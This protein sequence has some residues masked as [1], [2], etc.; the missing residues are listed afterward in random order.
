MKKPF[1]LI[2]IFLLL[3]SILAILLLISILILGMEFW[4]VRKQIEGNEL[5]N[6]DPK[7]LAYLLLI[8]FTLIITLLFDFKILKLKTISVYKDWVKLSLLTVVVLAIAIYVEL[9][10]LTIILMLL[11]SFYTIYLL[12]RSSQDKFKS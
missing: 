6:T 5:I 3:K 7:E 9:Q 11:L 4:T 12:I 1:F 8:F 10:W 2:K